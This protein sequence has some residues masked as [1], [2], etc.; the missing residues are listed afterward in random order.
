MMKKLYLFAKNTIFSYKN[1][2]FSEKQIHCLKL[3][4]SGYRAVSR[5]PC[6]FRVILLSFNN[7]IIRIVSL[8]SQTRMLCNDLNYDKC[9]E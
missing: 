5:Y 8:N 1:S 9:G 7:I 3:D 4:Y 2:V 6:T